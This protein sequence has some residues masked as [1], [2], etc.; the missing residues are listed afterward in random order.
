MGMMRVRVLDA[1]RVPV[2]DGEPGEI[3]FEG[4]ST[5]YRYHGLDEATADVLVDGW[6]LTGH[7]GYMDEVG[8]LH[9]GGRKKEIIKSGGF[10]VDRVEVENAI[11]SFPGVRDTAVVGVP[12]EHWGEQVVAFVVAALGTQLT[13]TELVTYLKSRVTGYKCLKRVW[14]VTELPRN[15]TGK[16]QRGHLRKQGA[17]LATVPPAGLS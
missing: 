8:K 4:P 12:D 6:L 10:S 9:F 17:K 5:M 2:P 1:D 16:V 14:F 7:L 15:P 13:E 11:L 3:A